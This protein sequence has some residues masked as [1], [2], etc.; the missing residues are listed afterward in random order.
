MSLDFCTT[1][2]MSDWRNRHIECNTLFGIP[3]SASPCAIVTLSE[4]NKCG[5]SVGQHVDYL[6]LD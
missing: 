2:L 5:S 4:S 1:V 6:Q 3:I